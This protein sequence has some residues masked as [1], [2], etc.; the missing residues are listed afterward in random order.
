[1][2]AV[3]LVSVVMSVYNGEK[4]LAEA[5]ES[6]LNQTFRDFEFI[7]ID[8][9]STDGTAAILDGFHDARIVRWQNKQN[10]GLS[11]SLNT[12]LKMARGKYIARMDSDDVS[13]PERFA[14]QVQ[15]LDEH[16]DIGVLGTAFEIIDEIGARGAE[17]HFPV[18][19]GLVR[20]QMFFYCPIVHPSVMMRRTVYEQFGGY[21]PNVDHSEDYELWLR[22]TPQTRIANMPDVLLQLRKHRGNKSIVEA[23]LD[24]HSVLITDQRAVSLALGQQVFLDRVRALRDPRSIT[25]ARDMLA[26]AKLIQQLYLEC[27]NSVSVQEKR[28]IRKDA[29]RKLYNIAITC[30]R[31]SPV[32]SIIICA[33]AIR[34]SPAS[35]LSM[36]VSTA[37]RVFR[38]FGRHLRL[39]SS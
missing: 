31:I 27:T 10:I 37:S 25:I 13:L 26:T 35:L 24:M 39:R 11:R 23:H 16:Q 32:S 30:I 5:V 1:M 38:S 29:G 18:E 6:I 4:Y 34:L 28:K 33:W 22:A 12:G 15:F 8:D 9:G 21:D 2:T 3:P 7:V 17:I 19:P 14:K 36:V 20:W